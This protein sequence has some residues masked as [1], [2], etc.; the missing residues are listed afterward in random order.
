A[1]VPRCRGRREGGAAPARALARRSCGRR[2]SRLASRAR[3]A[4]RWRPRRRSRASANAV[5]GAASLDVA[6]ALALLGSG[7]RQPLNDLEELL[8]PARAL[9]ESA[10][11]GFEERS[12]VRT[13]GIERG[14]ER[15]ELG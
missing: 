2:A 15:V 7:G 13:R 3:V 6:Q 12:R 5:A 14:V 10:E 8:R 4:H 11:A 1:G 9:A